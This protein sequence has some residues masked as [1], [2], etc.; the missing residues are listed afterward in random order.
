MRKR[1]LMLPSTQVNLLIKQA[2]VLFFFLFVCLFLAR[3]C[4]PMGDIFI[5]TNGRENG[6]VSYLSAKTR[7]KLYLRATATA[8]AMFNFPNGNRGGRE[9]R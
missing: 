7:A 1:G 6:G 4:G 9:R 5:N 2:L 3:C 8:A